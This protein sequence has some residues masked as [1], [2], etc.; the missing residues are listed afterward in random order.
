MCSG[1]FVLEPFLEVEPI[2]ISDDSPHRCSL[3][4][5]GLPGGLVVSKTISLTLFYVPVWLVGLVPGRDGPGGEYEVVG[6][7]LGFDFE[8]DIG[9]VVFRCFLLMFLHA[10]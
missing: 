7:V 2:T 4:L 5:S 10:Q 1:L 9:F 8:F 6:D 3:T